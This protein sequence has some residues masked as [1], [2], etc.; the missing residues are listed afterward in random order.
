MS[1]HLAVRAN[2]ILEKGPRVVSVGTT[3]FEVPEEIQVTYTQDGRIAL[4]LHKGE[5]HAFVDRGEIW[6]PPEIAPTLT[7]HYFGK[8]R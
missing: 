1:L 5:L 2:Q 3:A 8:R 4:I 6:M 7:R